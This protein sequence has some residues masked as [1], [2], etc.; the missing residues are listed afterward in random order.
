MF[1]IP[2]LDTALEAAEQV[3]RTAQAS[4][5]AVEAQR[6]AARAELDAWRAE[7][8]AIEDLSTRLQALG[9]AFTLAERTMDEYRARLTN[10]ANAA[11]DIGVFFGGLVTRTA[12]WGAI[13]SATALAEAVVK[14]QRELETDTRLI[15]GVFVD[16][17]ESP[18]VL[19]DEL[20]RLADSNVPPDGLSLL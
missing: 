13:T 12:E 19:N 15:T 11:L 9:P 8:R 4:L 7:Q 10:G 2:K 5:A 20:K 14:L 18:D 3:M 6:N 1:E 17:D 16:S